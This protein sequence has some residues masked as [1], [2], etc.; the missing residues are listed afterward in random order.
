[1]NLRRSE[2][3]TSLVESSTRRKLASKQVIMVTSTVTHDPFI[4][5]LDTR[6]DEVTQTQPIQT[7]FIVEMAD[8]QPTVTSTQTD[9]P[10]SSVTTASNPSSSLDAGVVPGTTI[11]TK[12]TSTSVPSSGR[13]TP[14]SHLSKAALGVGVCVLSILSIISI[15]YL[16]RQIKRRI[17]LRRVSKIPQPPTTPSNWSTSPLSSPNNLEKGGKSPSSAQTRPS[18]PRKLAESGS[19]KT[20]WHVGPEDDRQQIKQSDED[21]MALAEGHNSD[22][23]ERNIQGGLREATSLRRERLFRLRAPNH[24]PRP[25]A[26][27]RE[28]CHT[29]PAYDN[30][31][32]PPLPQQGPAEVRELTSIL[33]RPPNAQSD[34]V[35]AAARGNGTGWLGSVQTRFGVEREKY[36]PTFAEEKR[37]GCKKGVTFAGYQVR[38]FGLTPTPSSTTSVAG[39]SADVQ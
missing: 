36:K 8:G 37:P 18:T 3:S 25:Q 33:K 24:S 23:G 2:T 27:G 7:S 13:S 10:T 28:L 20:S 19:E 26:E 34:A 38:E 9:Q 35:T 15:Y 32:F 31:S 29:L 6:S 21:N 14:G 16:Y 5:F 1:M 30:S 17:R 4:V 39:R 11:P 12:A 22:A